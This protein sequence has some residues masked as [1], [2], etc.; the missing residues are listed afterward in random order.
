[1]L[2]FVFFMVS[3]IWICFCRYFLLVL[4][5]GSE[6][7]VKVMELMVWGGYCIKWYWWIFI[8]LIWLLVLGVGEGKGKKKRGI[9]W[10]V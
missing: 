8:F 9:F 1:M 5:E 10:C 6:E 4:V 3:W 7:C 2:L